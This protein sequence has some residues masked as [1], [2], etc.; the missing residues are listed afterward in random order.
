MVVRRRSPYRA[1]EKSIGYAFRKRKLLETALTHRSF[2]FENQDVEADNQ[3]LEFLGD[4]VLGFLTAAYLY[5]RFG[6]YHEGHLTTFRS[7]TNSGRALAKLARSI[8]LGEHLRMGKG[9]ERSGGRKRPSTLADAF[10]AVLGAVYLDGGI[11][12]AEKMFKKLLVPLLKA[13]SEDTWADNPKGKLQE[14]SQR[15][16]KAAPRYEVVK[17]DGPPHASIFTVAV[18]I[19]G[20][21]RGRGRGKNKQDAEARAAADALKKLE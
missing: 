9:E 14:L 6:E 16:W 7:Q 5:R 10:E 18:L 13:L 12:G 2:R 11:R 17:R 3:R 4:A 20:K 19:G 8:D 21:R 1:L 15:R